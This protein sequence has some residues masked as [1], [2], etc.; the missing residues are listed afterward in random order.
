[1]ESRRVIFDFLLFHCNRRSY[2]WRYYFWRCINV[3]QSLRGWWR[4][5]LLY[6]NRPCYFFNRVCVV[7]CVCW[8][9][10]IM[11]GGLPL[12][13]GVLTAV[14]IGRGIGWGITCGGK[15]ENIGIP[16]I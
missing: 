3:I 16:T 7:T 2:S 4:C 6:Y 9:R 8:I 15:P 12:V 14:G 5:L 10:G 13:Y 11:P 1:M